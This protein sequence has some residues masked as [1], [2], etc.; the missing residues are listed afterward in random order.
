M[1]LYLAKDTQAVQYG[2]MIK[3]LFKADG[4]L[5]VWAHMDDTAHNTI[6]AA[7]EEARQLRNM[8][9]TEVLGVFSIGMETGN[10]TQIYNRVE[11]NRI[12]DE[13]Y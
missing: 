6:S 4:S 11:L 10:I 12:F 5:K 13:E 1:S 3:S 2:L 9:D 8:S 7:V